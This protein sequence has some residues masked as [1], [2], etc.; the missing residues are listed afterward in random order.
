M[1]QVEFVKV[2]EEALAKGEYKFTPDEIVTLYETLATYGSDANSG[3]HSN[4][5][6]LAQLFW[7]HVNEMNLVTEGKLSM[8][9]EYAYDNNE[10]CT[11]GMIDFLEQ[12]GVVCEACKCTEQ[13]S[14]RRIV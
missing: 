9:L 6:A 10:D 8:A 13:C 12:H 11:N 7:K 2:I 3:G 5:A 14:Y 1:S 4:S